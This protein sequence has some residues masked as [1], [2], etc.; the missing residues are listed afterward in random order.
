MENCVIKNI[1]VL[2]YALPLEGNLV[3]A[4][5]GKHDNFELIIAKVL[6][7][8]G[9]EGVGYT[10]TGGIGGKAIATMMEIDLKPR[11]LGRTIVDLSSLNLYM[12]NAIHYVARGG[13]ASFAI[14]AFDIAFGDASLKTKNIALADA[15]GTRQKKLKHTMAV[16][17]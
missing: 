1:N 11:L 3:D 14:S 16:L 9:I 15:F 12:N 17:I 10:Y 8:N 7:S 6:L 2:Y 13:I 5:H 4:L